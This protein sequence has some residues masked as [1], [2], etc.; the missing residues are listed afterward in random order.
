MY[1]FWALQKRKKSNFSFSSYEPA[2]VWSVSVP[3]RACTCDWKH[4]VLIKAKFS[5]LVIHAE[6]FFIFFLLDAFPKLLVALVQFQHSGLTTTRPTSR[7]VDVFVHIT[8]LPFLGAFLQT[9]AAILRSV[10]YLDHV[11]Y[12]IHSIRNPDC[13][14]RFYCL[15][16]YRVFIS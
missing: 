7:F 12:K 5:S 13:G 15:V 9:V 16:L 4:T 14:G 1:S 6:V 11:S 8:A 10:S 3:V 2:I